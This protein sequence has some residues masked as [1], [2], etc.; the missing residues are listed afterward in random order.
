V[1]Q[2]K[3]SKKIIISI[4]GNNGGEVPKIH[5]NNNNNNNKP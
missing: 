1:K 4:K 2:A 3:Y 5:D